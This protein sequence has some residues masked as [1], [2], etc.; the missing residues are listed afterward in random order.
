[1]YIVLIFCVTIAVVFILN[2]RPFRTLEFKSLL[3]EKGLVYKWESSKNIIYAGVDLENIQCKFDIKYALID[4][5]FN[6]SNYPVLEGKSYKFLFAKYDN[7][8]SANYEIY[9]MSSDHLML[10]EHFSEGTIK[11]CSRYKI[12]R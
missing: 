12:M 1:M 4:M 9:I 11:N 6:D 7:M 2:N 8:R 10:I 5:I 3:R